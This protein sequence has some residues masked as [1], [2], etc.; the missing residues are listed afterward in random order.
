MTSLLKEHI[1]IS[2]D[3]VALSKTGEMMTVTEREKQWMANADDIAA[4]L[5]EINPNWQKNDMKNL[6]VEHLTLSK[7]ELTARLNDG[8]LSDILTFDKI[9]TQ[10]L[11]IADTMTDGIVKQFPMKFGQ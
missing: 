4:F 10:A 5:N 8:Q 2:A 9:Y 7:G 6:L 1:L 11:V 3:I